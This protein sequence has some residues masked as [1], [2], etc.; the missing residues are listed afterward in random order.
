MVFTVPYNALVIAYEKMTAFAFISI[1]DVLLK[2]IIVLLLVYTPLDRLKFYAL[3]LLLEVIVV[4]LVYIYYCKYNFR[5]RFFPPKI[6]EKVREET[7]KNSDKLLCVNMLKFSGW[8]VFGNFSVVCNTQG[9][10]LLLN[11]LGGPI[12]NAARVIAFNVQTA[13]TAFVSSFQTA[14]NPRITKNYASGNWEYMNEL[15]YISSRISYMLIFVIALPLLVETPFILRVWL[16]DIP[17]YAVVFTR[18]LIIVSMLDAISNPLT[19]AASATGQIKK[20]HLMV[21]GVLLLVLPVACVITLFVRVPEVVFIIQIFFVIVAQIVRILLCR[22]LFGLNA[23]RYTREVLYSVFWV[24]IAGVILP[25]VAYRL[26]GTSVWNNLL[27]CVVAFLSAASS[28]FFLGLRQSER[29]MILQ[30]LH[31]KKRTVL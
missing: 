13:I 10:N 27:V 2:L 25:L 19:I 5:L 15:V 30:K 16:H 31:I 22:S 9:L 3:M 26:L 14:M 20:Y 23:L 18:L 7:E 8:S 17:E 29:T 1:V 4:R 12:L 21:G 24:T 11:L 28:S 6:G